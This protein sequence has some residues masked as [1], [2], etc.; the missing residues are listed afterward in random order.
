MAN[1]RLVKR[2]EKPMNTIFS[3]LSNLLRFSFFFSLI[4][5]LIFIQYVPSVTASELN[6][7]TTIQQKI[8]NNYSKKFCNAIGIGLSTES[9]ARL[10]INEN[11]NPKFNSSLW[12]DIAFSGEEKVKEADSK[13]LFGLISKAIAKDCGRAIELYSNEDIDNFTKYFLSLKENQ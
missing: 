9:A 6:K 5:S 7:D 1:R 11:K 10:A 13:E 3:Q 12:L 8:A 2:A 4:F